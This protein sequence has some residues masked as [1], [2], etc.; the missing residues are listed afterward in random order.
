MT[1]I[2]IFTIISAVA[3]GGIGIVMFKIYEKMPTARPIP[4]FMYGKTLPGFTSLNDI[5]DDDDE[6]DTPIKIE[7]PE[8]MF[9]L[10]RE[11]TNDIFAQLGLNFGIPS[12]TTNSTVQNFQNWLD[13]REDDVE[14]SIVVEN[15]I[16]DNDAMQWL[17]ELIQDYSGSTHLYINDNIGGNALALIGVFDVVHIRNRSRISPFKIDPVD[18]AIYKNYESGFRALTAAANGR[19]ELKLKTFTALADKHITDDAIRTM[20]VN[21]DQVPF[22]PTKVEAFTSNEKFVTTDP[23]NVFAYIAQERVTPNKVMCRLF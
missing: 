14:I 12:V 21:K 17:I 3:L 10:T 4:P 16:F 11:E 8:N 9:T 19:L 1:L 18:Y 7:R 6:K 20:L 15:A 2:D 13:S 5:T 22:Y 23:S